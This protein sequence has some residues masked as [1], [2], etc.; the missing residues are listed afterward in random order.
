M[1]P[2][3]WLRFRFA[4]LLFLFFLAA[5][6]SGDAEPTLAPI[7]VV[8]EGEETPTH[9][10]TSTTVTLPTDT[11][12]LGI[13]S[14]P[15]PNTVFS[16]SAPPPTNAPAAFPTL[17]S[18]PTEVSLAQD[19]AP[20]VPQIAVPALPDALVSLG[21]TGLRLR[22]EPQEGDNVIDLLDE[23]TPLTII[24]RTADN[25]WVQVTLADGRS[26]WV[27]TQFVALNI[28]LTTISNAVSALVPAPPAP[29]ISDAISNITPR[30]REIYMNGQSLGN[31]RDVFSKVGD[32][33]TVGSYF[34]FPYGWGSYNLGAYS[35]L[36][37]VVN[38]YL[39]SLA[40]DANS[41]SNTSIAADNGWTTADVLNP[42]KAN[43]SLCDDGETPLACEYRLVKPAVALILF[44]TN[45]VV[46][47][48][49][50]SY[51][52]NLTQIVEFSIQQGVL[53]VLS[54][55]PPRVS[56]DTQ[57]DALNAV[58]RDVAATYSLPIWEYSAQMVDLPNR[59]L[60]SDGVHPSWPNG[61]VTAAAYFNE[62]N[63]RY[64]YTVRNLTALQVLDALLKSV[65]Y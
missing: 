19:V 24:G 27:M 46:N 12:V 29:V 52:A 11:P 10:Q 60:S 8:R 31:R 36:Q 56:F 65:L 34:L 25:T 2:A 58:V 37:G 50:G 22:S 42:A 55:V 16:T 35:D 4:L 26:G 23:S 6:N 45:D 3:H 33:L 57:V 9:A 41:F 20:V 63:L 62:E 7:V 28:D 15:G 64:G 1:K 61:E 38:F 51:R 47:L 39:A 17:T 43:G 53:P 13:T 14:T 30:A 48:D 44:G 40:R 54:T 32:S 59:G 49:A 18:F 5:C 21:S